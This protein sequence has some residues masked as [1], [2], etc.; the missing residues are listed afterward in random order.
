MIRIPF[1]GKNQFLTVCTALLVSVGAAGSASADL[2]GSWNYDEGSG[3]TA[4]DSSGNGNNGTLL[5]GTSFSVDVPAAIGS[6]TSLNF[7]GSRV[8]VPNNVTLNASSAV[9]IATWVKPSA[10]GGFEGILAKN[11]SSNGS[12]TN[13][14]GNYEL[15]LEAGGS[16]PMVFLYQRGAVNDTVGYNG[17]AATNVAGGL[18]SHLVV[19]NDGTNIQY[20]LNGSLVASSGVIAAGFG[21]TNTNDLFLG[22]RADS[23]TN[24][25]GLLDETA[26]WNEALTTGEALALY[27]LAIDTE[28]GYDPSQ[29]E[30]LFDVFNGILDSADVGDGRIWRP[31]SGFGGAAGDVIDLGSGFFFVNLDGVNGVGV[32]PEPASIAIWSLIGLGL[33]GFG[34]YQRRRKK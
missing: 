16:L 8:Q 6:G 24:L 4:G 34:F 13:H 12:G 2:V 7:N 30:Q 23:A 3:P 9:S 11:P 17:G 10:S 21:A 14:A 19:T 5:A 25:N 33:A 1:S 26:I 31:A 29:A 15:R 32:V 18:W 20:Y 28:L 27:N 22:G